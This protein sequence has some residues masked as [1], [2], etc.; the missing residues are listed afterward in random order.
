MT[1]SG[2][3]KLRIELRRAASSFPLPAFP[4]ERA[5]QTIDADGLLTRRGRSSR[6]PAKAQ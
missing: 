5:P 6:L 3:A 2:P 4:Q 1:L